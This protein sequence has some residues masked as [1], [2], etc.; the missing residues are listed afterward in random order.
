MDWTYKVKEVT[1]GEGDD[2]RSYSLLESNEYPFVVIQIVPT[3][4]DQ[5][6]DIIHK[7]RGAYVK[8]IGVFLTWRR[9]YLP[10][11]RTS[12]RFTAATR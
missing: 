12:P 8:L 9:R 10:T 11:R 7:L 3:A 5:R 6:D 1:V 4:A 2:S